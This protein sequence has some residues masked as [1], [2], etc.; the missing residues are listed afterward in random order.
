[1][2]GLENN[3]PVH[4]HS[5]DQLG[6]AGTCTPDFEAVSPAV[7]VVRPL[8]LKDAGGFLQ[9]LHVVTWVTPAR[10]NLYTFKSLA[11][12]MVQSVTAKLAMC[13]LTGVFDFIAECDMAH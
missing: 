9:Q 10:Q 7:C 13:G 1:M 2:N 5:H 4:N 3:D 8:A 6:K 12:G 11:I